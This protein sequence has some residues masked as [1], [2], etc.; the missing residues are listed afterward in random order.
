MSFDLEKIYKNLCLNDI[1]DF[2]KVNDKDEDAK[3]ARNASRSISISVPYSTVSTLKLS[4][5]DINEIVF[6]SI[7]REIN[8]DLVY[9]IDKKSIVEK[10]SIYKNE[11]FSEDFNMRYF[12]VPDKKVDNLYKLMILETSDFANPYTIVSSQIG[13]IISRDYQL[14]KN[15][16]KREMYMD[17]LGNLLLNGSKKIKVYIN[18]NIPSYVMYFADNIKKVSFYY[19][20]YFIK[21]NE[22]LR[23]TG[24]DNIIYGVN[25]T[26]NDDD[27]FKFKKIILGI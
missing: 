15:E 17:Y 22:S 4:F 1:I 19:S 6:E 9:F 23:V 13:A 20:D 12:L 3:V 26:T 7:I 2:Y 5:I 21:G 27:V 10:I 25:Y 16:C 14:E 24:I 8:K 11:I 18:P